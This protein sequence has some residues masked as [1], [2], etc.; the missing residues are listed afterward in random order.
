MLY[1]VVPSARPT[2]P[3]DRSGPGARTRILELARDS[4]PIVP[5]ARTFKFADAPAALAA[6]TSPHPPGKLALVNEG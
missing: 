2:R 6:L 5:M 4:D 1:T 3:V